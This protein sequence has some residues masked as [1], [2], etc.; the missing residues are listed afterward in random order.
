VER[1]VRVRIGACGYRRRIDPAIFSLM[2]LGRGPLSGQYDYRRG[3]SLHRRH[4]GSRWIVGGSAASLGRLSRRAAS[5]AVRSPCGPCSSTARR[6]QGGNR[7]ARRADARLS[8][9]CQAVDNRRRRDAGGRSSLGRR[10]GRQNTFAAQALVARQRQDG[11]WGPNRNLPSD[12][13]ATGE[14]LWALKESGVLAAS[15]PYISVA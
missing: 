6:A 10:T 1:L 13:Y 9:G 4:A 15:D 7:P 14:T 2:S 11:G 5:S 8:A 12:A 3:R